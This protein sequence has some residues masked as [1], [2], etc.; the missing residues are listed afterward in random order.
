MTLG[1]LQ[2]KSEEMFLITLN[3]QVSKS[4]IHLEAPPRDLSPTPCINNLLHL[5]RDILSTAS[6]AENRD[7]DVNK[8]MYCAKQDFEF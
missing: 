8:V 6:I 4:L 5:L 7:K 2:E 3:D 1:E